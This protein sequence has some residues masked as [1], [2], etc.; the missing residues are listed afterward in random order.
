MHNSNAIPST[1]YNS[2]AVP[3]TEHIPEN[4]HQFLFC[5]RNGVL[6][7]NNFTD[8]QE[9]RS[10]CTNSNRNAVQV[11]SGSFT[12]LTLSKPIMFSMMNDLL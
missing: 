8:E 6:E 12:P 7:D 5:R 4:S 3:L 1:V 2:S 11:R 9:R 10:G